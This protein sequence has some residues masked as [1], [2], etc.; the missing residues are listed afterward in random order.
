MFAF[1]DD[2][3]RK[4]RGSVVMKLYELTQDFKELEALLE[5]ENIIK[6]EFEI[7]NIL[8][9]IKM[10]IE[11]KIDNI[12]S[13]I[14]SKIAMAKALKNEEYELKKRR[15]REEKQAE[16]LK[17]YLSF[18]MQNIN[19]LKFENEKHKVSFRDSTSVLIDESVFP[20]DLKIKEVLYK[21]PSKSDLKDRLNAGEVI[22]GVSLISKANIQI[23]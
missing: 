19:K 9:T 4:Q 1:C 20:D 15:E 5:D 23:K 22:N 17:E 13:L 3:D 12:A 11:L 10:D 8:E 6:D 7:K 2:A 14:K 18:E 21:I 16:A